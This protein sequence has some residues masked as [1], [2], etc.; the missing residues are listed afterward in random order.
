MA[1]QR[2]SL[3]FVTCLS[4]MF[5]GALG[6]SPPEEGGLDFATPRAAV[7]A[8]SEKADNI[9]YNT[10]CKVKDNIPGDSLFGCEL[11]DPNDGFELRVCKLESGKLWL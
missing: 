9:D 1:F 3:H 7:V 2:I 8:E 11:K 6:T 10:F 5:L 4:L